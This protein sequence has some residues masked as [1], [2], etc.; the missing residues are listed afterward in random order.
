MDEDGEPG[1][2]CCRPPTMESEAR[3]STDTLAKPLGAGSAR[4]DRG[5]I[6]EPDPKPSIINRRE[7]DDRIERGFQLL[8][9]NLDQERATVG[10]YFRVVGLRLDPDDLARRTGDDAISDARIESLQGACR[11]C[12][13]G[14]IDGALERASPIHSLRSPW[15]APL[16]ISE[17]RIRLGAAEKG[18]RRLATCSRS[19]EVPRCTATRFCCEERRSLFRCLGTE[20]LRCVSHVEGQSRARFPGL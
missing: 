19:W 4:D 1:L 20:L 15:I 16:S 5:S 12:G 10:M 18:V 14:A 11:A 9:G 17:C 8:Q 3:S 6:A 7:G 13:N 2:P